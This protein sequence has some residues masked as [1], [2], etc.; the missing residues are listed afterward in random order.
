MYVA[1][2][3]PRSVGHISTESDYYLS[4][5]SLDGTKL[6]KEGAVALTAALQEC[7]QLQVLR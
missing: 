3:V 5:L 4:F 7:K 2:L 6:G 1:S